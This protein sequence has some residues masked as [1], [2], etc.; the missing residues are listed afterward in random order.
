MFVGLYNCV[1]EKREEEEK[2]SS[3]LVGLTLTA[4]WPNWVHA[5]NA[6]TEQSEYLILIH[7]AHELEFSSSPLGILC[8]LH[9]LLSP[10][11]Y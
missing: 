6:V 2:D 11:L 10:D 4:T 1:A 7:H 5:E 8:T 9:C 3:S